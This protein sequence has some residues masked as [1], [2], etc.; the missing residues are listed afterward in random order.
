M[1]CETF[2]IKLN[3]HTVDRKR[4]QLMNNH[5]PTRVPSCTLIT[6]WGTAAPNRR[7]MIGSARF[8]GS[9]PGPGT[10]VIINC[11]TPVPSP[12]NRGE[13]WYKTLAHSGSGK[14]FSSS[15]PLGSY[16]LIPSC[17]RAGCGARAPEPVATHA[18]WMTGTT[19]WR[20]PG[21]S[22]IS[23]WRRFKYLELKSF[24]SSN[25]FDSS[26]R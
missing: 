17:F 11:P 3:F 8:G 19:Q 7:L 25:R 13:R 15:R 20:W 5:N 26:D 21:S 22:L 24:R 1:Y 18:L 10:L 23:S 2:I 12:G 14:Y 9:A 6:V 16:Q 4:V